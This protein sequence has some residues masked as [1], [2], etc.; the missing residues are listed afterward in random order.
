[1]GKAYGKREHGKAYGKRE[2]RKPA[3]RISNSYTDYI[4]LQKFLE[5]L[6]YG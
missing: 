1:M 2:H 4:K 6:K 3:Q 5:W